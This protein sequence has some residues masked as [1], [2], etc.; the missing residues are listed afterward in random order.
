MLYAALTGEPPFRRATAP[1][2]IAAHLSAPPP[3]PSAVAGV[4]AAFDAVM[5]RALAK[6]PEDR[7]PS[8]GDL[9]RAAGAAARGERVTTDERVVARGP[10]APGGDATAVVPR[11]GTNGSRE[12]VTS[13]VRGRRGDAHGG[14]EPT[15]LVRGRPGAE[16]A[17]SLVR[18]RPGAAEGEDATALVRGRH[19][20][21]ADGEATAHVR[22]AAGSP[23]A[24]GAEAPP[25]LVAAARRR[26][27]RRRVAGV[28]LLVLALAGAGALVSALAGGG[29][30]TSSTAPLS[31][32]DVRGAAQDFAAA[33]GDE[34]PTAL[35]AVL[36]GDVRRVTPD[37]VQQGRAAV[38]AVYRRQFAADDI[39]GYALSDL[40]VRAG[41]A[42]RAAGRYS[43]DRAGAP[44][45]TGRI[46][47]G[48][49]REAG[50]PRIALLAATPDP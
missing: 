7:Y 22:P 43:V 10:A 30:S 33:Y 44:D 34:D 49:V 6:R 1:D 35:R 29:P 31:A 8:A 18:G 12:G 13:L 46:V 9:A 45:V 4:D 14:E 37:G 2:A 26:R 40:G 11:V 38:T 48:V 20:A 21:G 5:G 41:E 23:V 3:R 19:A 47:F 50:R 24:D 39:R 42:G 32:D 17:T 15:A 27:T 28:V 16:E 36:A 25:G